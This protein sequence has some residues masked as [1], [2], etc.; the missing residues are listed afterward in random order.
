MCVSSLIVY[1]VWLANVRYTAMC[2][3]TRTYVLT[4]FPLIHFMMIKQNCRVFRID[5]EEEGFCR[6]FYARQTTMPRQDDFRFH[7]HIF[8]DAALFGEAFRKPFHLENIF[9]S[10][11]SS[12]L[13]LALSPELS[14]SLCVFLQLF[15]WLS[16]SILLVSLKNFALWL[17]ITFH[18]LGVFIL[19]FAYSKVPF[20]ASIG[21]S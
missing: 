17:L 20:Y 10:I 11:F 9:F 14:L 4:W 6:R 13:S 8:W 21:F 18:L 15:V 1:L 3:C 5:R 19:R 7:L 12:L 16:V 2:S